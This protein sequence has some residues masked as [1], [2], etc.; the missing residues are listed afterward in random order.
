MPGDWWIRWISVARNSAF[1][2]RLVSEEA[3]RS[4]VQSL[5]I[6]RHVFTPMVK[7][8]AEKDMKTWIE[9]LV[10]AVRVLLAMRFGLVISDLEQWHWK[11]ATIVQVRFRV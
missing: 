5:A 4:F 2:D 10:M 9:K 1:S 3:L 7:S 11:V 6:V 8:V